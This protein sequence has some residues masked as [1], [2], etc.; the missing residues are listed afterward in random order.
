MTVDEVYFA[1]IV[2][3]CHDMEDTCWVK[4]IYFIYDNNT[5]TT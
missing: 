4:Q 1:M 3:F 5:L 2:K